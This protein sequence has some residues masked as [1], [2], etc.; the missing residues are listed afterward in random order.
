MARRFRRMRRRSSSRGGFF[1]RRSRGSSGS[2]NPMNVLLPAALY[3]ATRGYI[4]SAISPLTSKIPVGNYGDELVLG[5]AGYF[6]AKKGS[7]FIKNTGMAILTVEAASLGNQLAGTI[8]GSS[9][10]SGTPYYG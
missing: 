9:S 7:G 1:K 10:S 3:G 4:A 2:S 8:G 5:L 6:M